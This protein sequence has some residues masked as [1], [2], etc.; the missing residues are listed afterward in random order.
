M[1]TDYDRNMKLK[2]DSERLFRVKCDENHYTY[3]YIDQEKLTFSSKMFEQLTKRPDYILSIPNI[4]S[5]FVDVKAYKEHLF[6][7]EPLEYKNKAVPK[8]FRLDVD[9]IRKY[10]RLQEETSMKVWYAVMSV[11]DN[12]VTSDIHFFPIDRIRKFMADIHNT[13][14][15]WG[16]VQV[17]IEC[18]TD[19]S[20]LAQNKCGDC[21]KKYCEELN[22]LLKLDDTLRKVRKTQPRAS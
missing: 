3:M 6:F 9:E 2:N 19:S 16:Y 8:A 10:I 12:T 20:K 13:N 5:I 4:G 14:P 17:P 21:R 7:K 1:T 11:Q 15:E 22:E 18:S